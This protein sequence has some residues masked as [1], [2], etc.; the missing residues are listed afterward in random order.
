MHT[1]TEAERDPFVSLHGGPEE[2]TQPGREPTR[3][4]MACWIGALVT[5]AVYY[6]DH[7]LRKSGLASVDF[8]HPLAL[9]APFLLPIFVLIGSR[10]MR[11][12]VEPV[13]RAAEDLETRRSINRQIGFGIALVV[14]S[15]SLGLVIVSDLLNGLAEELTFGICFI[16]LFGG[17][18]ALIH[19]RIS[20]RR[21]VTRMRART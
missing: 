14:L 7:E 19:V 6:G 13:P 5:L 9:I 4:T 8:L 3:A 21:L 12:T 2:E 16:A 1:Q 17:V 20:P 10:T 15:T 18:L 11:R